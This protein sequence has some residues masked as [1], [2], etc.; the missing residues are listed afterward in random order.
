MRYLTALTNELRALDVT[1][2]ITDETTKARGPEIELKVE[3]TSALAENLI[4]LEYVTLGTELRRMLS[5]VKQRTSAHNTELREFRL[6]PHGVS[7]AEDVESAEAIMSADGGG[8]ES[9]RNRKPR[10]GES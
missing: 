5:V 3:G 10:A 2:L 8:L 6:T 7:I 9:R 1:T 4:L